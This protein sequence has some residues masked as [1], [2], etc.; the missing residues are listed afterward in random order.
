MGAIAA[1]ICVYLSW[2]SFNK[3]VF[4]IVGAITAVAYIGLVNVIWWKEGAKLRYLL[5][6]MALTMFLAAVLA[7]YVKP[8]F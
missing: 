6:L 4:Y 2:C 1:G 8:L 5:A 7:F 3:N